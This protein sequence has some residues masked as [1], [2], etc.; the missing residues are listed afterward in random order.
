MMMT[1]TLLHVEDVIART[2]SFNSSLLSGGGKGVDLSLFEEGGQLPGIYQ[3]DIILNGSRVDSLE[4]PFHT[5]K[6]ENGRPYLKT[7]LTQEMLARY[8]VKTEE[9]PALFRSLGGGSDTSGER[10]VC[11]DLSAIP[12]ATENYQFA[13]QQLVLGIPQ[14]A[15][16]PLLRGIAPEVLWDDGIP[17]FLLNWQANAG[18]SE[19]RGYIKD[20]EDYFWS[21]LEPGINIGS[22][23]IR[24]LT[25]WNKSSG[26]SG[27]WESLYIRAERGLNSLK[28]RLT[29]GENYT[30]SDIFDS[31]PFRGGMLSS[32]E[33]MVPYNQREFAPVV[34]GIARTQARI[35][36]RQNGYLI[37]SQT[38]APG[39]FA[40][41][42]LPVTG[43]GSDLQV[44]VRESDGTVQVFTVPFT[45]PAIALREGY[46]K[47]NVMAGQYRS[48]DD[49]VEDSTLGQVMGMYGLP[50][51]LTVFGGL[52]GA[53]H[54]QAAALGLGW[55]L[56]KLGAVSL[57]TIH[58]RG[59][60]KG[61]NYETGNTWRI[62]YN[63][64]FELTGTSFTAASY[65]YSSSGYH[66]LSDV[67]ETYRDDGRFAYRSTDS[68]T[69]R[70]T[71][72]LSQSL[73]R[74][75]YLGLNG[76]RDEYRDRPHQDYIGA[77]YGASWNRMSLS[78]NWSRNHSTRGY[79]GSK[80]RME[81]SISIWMSIPL[82]SWLGRSDNNISAT[83]Q[84]QRSTEQNT[85]YELGLNGRA[86]DR[87]LFWEV[88]EQMVS[89]SEYNTDTS[90]LNLRW[91]GTYGE[92][93]GMYSYS[94]NMRQI[95]AGMSGSMVAH[96]EGVTFGQR[97][98]DTVTLVAAPGVSGASVGDWPGVR[99]DF[100]G[101]A[102][103]GYASPYQENVITLDPTTFPEDAEVPQT[104]SR[105]VPTKGAVVR[106]GFRT[107]V[108]G[109]ALVSLTRQ[110]GSSLPFGA[111]VTLEGKPGETS[112]SAG[113]VDDKGRVYLS[114][115]PETGK[116]KAQWGE[117]SICHADYR[118]P[119]EKGPAGIFLTRTVC[120]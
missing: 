10:G 20:V 74:W 54:Y 113:V 114:G 12:Q 19:Y 47:Y 110:D 89:G 103:A 42:D 4:M 39:A 71:V 45:T 118:L 99:T 5:E 76:S 107:R 104:D 98:G 111:I 101:Y 38:V 33:S 70:T 78:V 61:Y 51:G 46:L 35:E 28:S 77:S 106:A 90:R 56:G 105:V 81:D 65:Q 82:E 60:Q 62:R 55:S 93:A 116:L 44:T 26:Q 17:A 6:D 64:S 91:S 13:A 108:G 79:Y 31:V 97:A 53:E 11:A 67:L 9:Y 119:E 120:M 68:R 83:A 85:R 92:L 22:W 69:S 88:H 57:D 34:R 94:S 84:M 96:G 29:L 115:L 8:G 15:L 24:N 1:C 63:K 66:T 117:N 52:Q 36:V 50:W 25:T 75:G 80:S 100:R 102:L 73:G 48:S 40:L 86:F 30:P 112:G 72:N 23:R 18:R 37:Q 27:K 109:R 58:S 2:Y 87:R 95:N 49:A 59:Q 3:T 16:R 21:S 41:T 14:V 7:C 32:D 43:S